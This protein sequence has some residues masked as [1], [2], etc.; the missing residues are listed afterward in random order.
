M[1]DDVASS[2]RQAL[3][4]GSSESRAA[5]TVCLDK[6]VSLQLQERDGQARTCE[7]EMQLTDAQSAIEEMESSLRMKEMEYDR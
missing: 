2:I 1:L 7:L 5:L 4:M 3:E 6:V